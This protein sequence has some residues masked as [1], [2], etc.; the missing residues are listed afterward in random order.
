MI[1][2]DTNVFF[3]HVNIKTL[4]NIVNN[5]L[6]KLNEWFKANKLPINVNKTKHTFFHKLKQ[7]DIC[8]TTET[9]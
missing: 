7:R 8:N 4:F 3:S 1:A 9:A 6:N 5:K 2:D